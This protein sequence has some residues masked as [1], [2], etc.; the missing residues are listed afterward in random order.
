MEAIVAGY[1][2]EK[3]F[4][5]QKGCISNFKVLHQLIVTHAIP[6]SYLPRERLHQLARGGVDQGVVAIV[7]PI[8]FFSLEAVVQAVFERGKVPL[9][10]LLD[11]VTDIHNLGA[12]ARTA[13]CMGV[14]A[15]V[16]P[17]VGSGSLSATAMK[18]SAGA[19]ATLPICRV[20]SLNQAL[21]Y[22]QESGLVVVACHEE[23]T[24]TPSMVDLSLPVALLF[25]GEATGIAAKQL[26]L[27][28]DQVA[29]PMK[30]PIASLNVSVAVGML[31]YEVFRQ[32][33]I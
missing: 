7:S 8:P 32:R 2:I 25:G 15:L 33:S 19:L 13:L 26:K 6:C 5:Q 24:T 28:T 4:L 27:V 1:A 12:I 3:I 10:L 11:G 9:I 18:T 16:V 31:L 23:A 30:G 20:A 22:L 14:D 17:S 21:C 29:I